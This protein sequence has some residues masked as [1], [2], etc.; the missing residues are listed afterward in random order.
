MRRVSMA[1]RDELLAAVAERYR[2]SPRADRVRILDEFTA[3]TG[4]HRKHAMRLLRTAPSKPVAAR[5]RRRLYDEAVR[6][7]LILLWEAS[8]RICGKRLKALIPTLVPAMER[9]GHLTLAPEIRA[10]LLSISAATIDRALRPQREHTS[11]GGRRRGAA[12]AIRRAIPVRTF[13][14]WGDPPPGFVEA[15]LVAH[16]GPSASGAFVQTLVLTD[17]ATGWTE[18]APLLLREQTL[19]VAVLG[20]LRSL[21]PFPLLG[22]DTDNDTVFMNETLRDYCRDEGIELTRCRP[23][24]KNDQ[25]HIEQKNGAIVRRMVGYRRLEGVAAAKELAR[26]YATVRLFVNVF[27]PSF[28]LAEKERDGA[29]VRK[30]YHAP[31][32]PCDQLMADPR[33]SAE[34]RAKVEALRNR[35][36]PVRLLAE[37][38][39]AQQGLVALADRPADAVTPRAPVPVAEFLAELRTAWEAGEVRPTA[40][41]KPKA[42]RGRRRPDPLVSVTDELRGWFEA[43]PLRTGGELLTRLQTAYPGDYPDG[44]LRT[45]QRRLKLWR[46]EIATSLVL[47]PPRAPAST[48]RP[49]GASA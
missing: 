14:D 20:E 24:R 12:S 36:D 8:D 44:L 28:K 49:P 23:Y 39:A 32:T 5:Q 48:T 19:L 29:R 16:S 15:D 46:T 21:L 9:H 25:A 4:Y 42:K 45:V 31:R 1:T 11:A 17:I 3:V 13:A 6:A 35:L 33:A 10:A 34:V 47:G 38:R 7:A 2:S 22:L 43:D 40:Q 30:R 18:C 41:A 26:L 27:Q 37:I